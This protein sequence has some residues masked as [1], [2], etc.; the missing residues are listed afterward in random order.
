[1][2]CKRTGLSQDL[3][4]KWWI[5]MS[6][7]KISFSHLWSY[8][9][10]LYTS[11]G[12]DLCMCIY[13]VLCC[14]WVHCSAPFHVVHVWSHPSIFGGHFSIFGKV[15]WHFGQIHIWRTLAF[16]VHSYWVYSDIVGSLWKIGCRNNHPK[17]APALA[18]S[19]WVHSENLG[20]EITTQK[21][22]QH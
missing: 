15:L 10:W 3:C 14:L 20:I 8:S 4:T 18:H 21:M 5:S 7:H 19:P 9:R 22:R 16:W 2:A 1:M 13:A 6:G 17:N 11:L 12:W